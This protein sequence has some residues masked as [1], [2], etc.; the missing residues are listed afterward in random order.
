MCTLLYGRTVKKYTIF[1]IKNFT[2][3]VSNFITR[4][5]FLQHFSVNH[6]SVA[7]VIKHLALL[8]RKQVKPTGSVVKD[9]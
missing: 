8:Y 4:L 7:S 1:I 5:F 9:G 3:Y 2:I 6:D